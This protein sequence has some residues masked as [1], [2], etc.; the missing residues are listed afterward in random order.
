MVSRP[1]GGAIG[2]LAFA[3]ATQSM[4]IPYEKLMRNRY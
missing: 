4:M 1:L 3:A 2:K